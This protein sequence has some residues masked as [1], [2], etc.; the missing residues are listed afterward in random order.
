[1]GA[2]PYATRAPQPWGRPRPHTPASRIR[3]SAATGRIWPYLAV[4]GRIPGLALRGLVVTGARRVCRRAPGRSVSP[5]ET[6]RDA[7]RRNE[8]QRDATRRNEMH[9]WRRAAH[10]CTRPATAAYQLGA[11]AVHVQYTSA[12]TR[13]VRIGALAT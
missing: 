12:R 11:Y 9:A 6:Q 10:A 8:T 3:G 5:G 7:T 4:S 2:G 13:H 1:M